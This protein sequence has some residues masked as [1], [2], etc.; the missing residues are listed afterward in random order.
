MYSHAADE[1]VPF[2]HISETSTLRGYKCTWLT[3]NSPK[4]QLADTKTWWWENS[5]TPTI[6]ANFC[7]FPCSVHQT[8]A[9]EAVFA[10]GRQQI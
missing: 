3:V 7:V 9:P 8:C 1:H 10:G 4:C 2:S 6:D 5:H